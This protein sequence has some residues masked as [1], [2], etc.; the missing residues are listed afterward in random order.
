MTDDL[1]V[2]LSKSVWYWFTIILAAV[3]GF[4]IFLI[5]QDAGPLVFVR[6]FLGVIF[7]LFLPGFALIKALFPNKSRLNNPSVSMDKLEQ[8]ALSIGL[9]LALSPLV[10]LILN[11]TPWGIR[12]A[13]VTFSLLA[14]TIILGT[15]AL[16]RAYIQFKSDVNEVDAVEAELVLEDSVG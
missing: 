4:L 14:L 13:S 9:S 3:A 11:F 5:P 2:F 8:V 10:G 7:I 16:F 12:L 1:I 6:S 15:V